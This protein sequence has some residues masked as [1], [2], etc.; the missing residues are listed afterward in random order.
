MLCVRIAAVA[1]HRWSSA[2]V[3]AVVVVLAAVLLQSGGARAGALP[4]W[5]LCRNTTAILCIP[6]VL[7]Y[8][9]ASNC[10]LGLRTGGCNGGYL[11]NPNAPNGGV[12]SCCDGF[13]CPEG[14]SCAVPCLEGAY[15]KAL[16]LPPPPTLQSCAPYA[17]APVVPSICP[18]ASFQ[19]PCIAG[20]YWYEYD[21]PHAN[22]L[23]TRQ[24][25]ASL[26]SIRAC[27]FCAFCVQS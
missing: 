19:F 17:L 9:P 26:L 10:Q 22:A 11:S 13:A 24:H 12:E 21:D 14:L 15:C 8:S 20:F 25:S 23:C 3:M 5:S 1:A 18:G 4:S 2:T 27:P 16:A 7:P 6:G